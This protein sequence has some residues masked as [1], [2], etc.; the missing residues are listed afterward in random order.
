[1]LVLLTANAAPFIALH[2]EWMKRQQEHDRILLVYQDNKPACDMSFQQTA[3]AVTQVEYFG[4]SL[5]SAL[6]NVH[7]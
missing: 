5:A 6:Y 2:R 1:M 4:V 3:Q 7:F